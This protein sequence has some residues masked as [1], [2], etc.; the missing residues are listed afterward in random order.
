M[1]DLVPV[2]RAELE[3]LRVIEAASRR[4]VEDLRRRLGA[5]PERWR[6]LEAA[7]GAPKEGR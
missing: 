4:L 3:R 1:S 7:L 5:L 6:A 2:D